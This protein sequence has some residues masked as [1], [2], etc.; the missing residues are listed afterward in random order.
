MSRPAAAAIR[1]DTTLHDF[2]VAKFQADSALLQELGERLVGQPHIALA[3]LI[4]NAY[5]ADATLCNV[6]IASDQITVSD[7]GHGM[8]EDE[9]IKY[10]MTIG[11][12]NKQSRNTSPAFRRRVTGSKGV[13]RLSAQ[14]LAHKLAI[15]T[16]SKSDDS[17]QLR[18]T[19]NW[20]DAVKS[21]SLTEAEAHYKT[22]PRN[23][24]FP[25]QKPHGTRVIMTEVKEQWDIDK[26]RDLGRQL[27]ML[28]PPP[29]RYG[30]L[31]THATDPDDFRITLTST[32]GAVKD[33]F[34]QQMKVMLRN[35]LAEISGELRRDGDRTRAHVRVTFRSGERYSENFHV[36]PLITSA[37]WLIRI[38]KLSG[39]QAGG[40]DV[41][42]ARDYFARFGGV[43]V[44]DGRFRLPYYG[45]EQDW[46]GIEF[47]HSHRRSRS[48]LLPERLHVPRALNDLP[49][50]G[51]LFG[52][53]AINTG[54]E[55]REANDEQR[56]RGEFLKI[57]VTRDRLV[58]NEAYREL[59]RAVRW[60]LDY[61][62]TRQRL[63]EQQRAEVAP[64]KELATEKVDRVRSLLVE[65][66][67]SYPHDETIAALRNEVDGLSGALVDEQRADERAR[68]LLGP[69]AAAGMAALALEHESRKEMRSARQMLARLI[70]IGE[71]ADA[72][73]V[74]EIGQQ[75]GAWIDR[76]EDTRKLFGPLLDLDDREDVG[77][78]LARQV[79]RQV[80]AN[81][82]PL[83]P[84]MQF[85]LSVPPDLYLPH[86]TFAEWNSLF[87]NVIFNASNAT[88]DLATRRVLC[89]GGRTGRGT[90]VRV[91]DNG[92]G[93]DYA[94]S[95]GLFE[96]FAR[97][98][99]V[100]E[101]R[102]ALGLGGMGLGLTI[103]RMIASQ[104]RCRVTFV[105]PSPGWATAFQLSWSSSK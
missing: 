35:H 57:Q 6:S 88:L 49:T 70:R 99:K 71:R 8:T 2:K 9:F 54:L 26:T 27:W 13:G 46:L 58:S 5:D 16:S 59:R 62:A 76:L 101:E 52:L 77:A 37:K 14:F 19:V 102:R 38:F 92:G 10:W 96:P 39:K 61:Y 36:E 104:R 12:Q 74:V 84:G 95:A 67:E 65:A 68:M 45:A 63:K 50:Q 73:R 79:L 7:N 32:L 31:V 22:E 94:D 72:P 56:E 55:A 93:V 87:Q 75:I 89:S 66:H 41:A 33:T 42:T 18:A 11:T 3:E 43:T 83:V 103:V 85:S 82:R 100:S 1:S 30:S 64:Q 34:E 29:S 47:D 15:V 53:V 44:Y 21:G 48:V 24:S 81:V 86:A 17:L 78:L 90:W 4:K 20:D 40:V 105:K 91:E 51:R 60:S 25:K 28:Q 98:I 97:Q 23:S 69:L 80:I